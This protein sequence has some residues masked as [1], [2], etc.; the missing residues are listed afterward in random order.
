MKLPLLE[1]TCWLELKMQ[2]ANLLTFLQCKYARLPPWVLVPPAP[3]CYLLLLEG[4]QAAS[5]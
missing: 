2:N 5:S 1:L 3:Y 4:K